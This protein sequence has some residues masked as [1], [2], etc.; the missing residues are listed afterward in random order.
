VA[1]VLHRRGPPAERRGR[2][3]YTTV[4]DATRADIFGPS[5]TDG[6]RPNGSTNWEDGLRMG[7]YFLPRPSAQQP[8]L[9]VFIT[10]GDPNEVIKGSVSEADYQTTV[11]LGPL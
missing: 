7:R 2:T 6:Y 8:H 3:T 5:I 10:D 1:G 11:P 9:T 4:T